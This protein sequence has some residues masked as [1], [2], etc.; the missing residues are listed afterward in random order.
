[1]NV[2][3]T[4]LKNDERAVFS[5][6]ELYSRYGY[7]R[8]KVSKFEEYDLYARNKS[9][10]ISENI[11]TFTDTDGRL[12]ALKPDVTLSIIKNIGNDDS[13]THKLYYN[14]NVYRTS[15]GADG[16]REI[17][18]TGLECVGK[19]DLCATCEVI[20]LAKK[21]LEII[22]ENT[23]LDISHMGFVAGLMENIGIEGADSDSLLGFIEH[24][25]V[26]AIKAFCSER[27]ISEA[28]TRAICDIT[29]L[30]APIG[31]AL[32]AVRDIVRG[33][34]MKAAYDELCGIY[35]VLSE[36]GSADG[37][38]VDFS[39]VNDMNYYNG[40]TFKGF[41]RGI[42]DGILSGGSYDSLMKKMGKRA[43]AIGFA[44]YLDMLER[45]DSE[46][47]KYDVDTVLLYDS[48]SDMAQVARAAERMR[49]EGRSVRC[50]L[51]STDGIR[52]RQLLKF[53]E[54]GV[55]V[56]ETND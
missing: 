1:M 32:E 18:Q 11:L 39:T 23:I 15:A 27:A 36:C 5:L 46:S 47:E 26:S 19:I 37:I 29:A 8:H 43:G 38:Y 56:L 45:L 3:F 54:G 33:K 48:G 40:V 7:V 17:M 50:E 53:S 24:K 9:F 28:D 30:Y 14:E 44:V 21:S 4:A 2:S 42:P 52:Y 55:S 34:K 41:V 35:G 16:F 20:L 12:M 51:G 25:N 10:L 31:D 6:R 49:A 22:S 13:Q